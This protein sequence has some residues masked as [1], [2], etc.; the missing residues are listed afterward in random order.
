[1]KLYY[2]LIKVMSQD[3]NEIDVIYDIIVNT[4]L[5][6]DCLYVMYLQ[7]NRIQ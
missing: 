4:V 5:M 2:S 1:M 7:L 6:F 3:S